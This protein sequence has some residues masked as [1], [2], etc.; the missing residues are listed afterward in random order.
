MR[1]ESSETKK[2]DSVSFNELTD[3]LWQYDDDLLRHCFLLV[4]GDAKIYLQCR[5]KTYDSLICKKASSPYRFIKY[6][7]ELTISNE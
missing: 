4:A 7:G 2:R 5:N 1:I 3:G 6:G